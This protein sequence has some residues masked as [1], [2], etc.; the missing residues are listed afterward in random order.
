MN[1]IN[2]RKRDIFVT[3]INVFNIF[4]KIIIWLMMFPSF[5][6]SKN[7]NRLMM[8]VKVEYKKLN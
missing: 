4:N 5:Q 8:M 3:Y 1:L 7:I 2:A 6:C